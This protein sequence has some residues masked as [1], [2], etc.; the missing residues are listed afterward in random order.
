MTS[1]VSCAP[2]ACASPVAGQG[3]SVWARLHWIWWLLALVVGAL[4]FVLIRQWLYVGTYRFFVD[5]RASSAS[6]RQ[7]FDLRDGRVEPQVLV[8]EDGRLSFPLESSLPSRLHLRAVPA[9]RATLEIA[10][11]EHG[12][13]RMLYRR[14]LSEP[15]DIAQPL[16]PVRGL[17]EIATRGE[18]RLSD[19]RLVQE[20]V[21]TPWLVVLLASA[22]GAALWSARAAPVL[23]RARWAR[24]LVLGGATAAFAVGLILTASEL[25][26]RSLDE[27]LPS[28]ITLPRRELGEA[29][30]DPRWQDS[31][32]YGPRLAANV[33]TT[34]EWQHGDIV[35]LG[36]LPPG[37]ARHPVYRFPL[38]TDAEGFRNAAPEVVAPE[39]AALGDSFTDALT[40]PAELT[41][42]SLLA[43]RL[44]VGVR[45]YGTAGFGPAQELLVLKQYVLAR[46]PRLVVV[47]FFAGNDLQD[48]ERFETWQREGMTTIPGLGWKFKRVVA[49]FDQLYVMSLYQGFSSLLRA[50]SARLSRAA[51]PQAPAEYS[52]DDPAA[53]AP[54]VARFESGL[55]TLPVGGRSLAFAFLPPYLSGLQPS[56]EELLASRRFELTRAS[57]REMARLVRAQGGELV[58]MFIPSKAQ[59]YLPLLE[60]GFPAGELRQ[61][62]RFCQRAQ[63]HAPETVTLLRNRLALNQ[64]MREFCV[65]EDLA[66]LDLTADLQARLATG[67]NV[68]FPDDSHW[69]AAGHEVGA[70][71]LA[72]FIRAR[73]GPRD[74]TRHPRSTSVGSEGSGALAPRGGAV[75]EYKFGRHV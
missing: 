48:A 40:L 35:R 22:L 18:F 44:G 12:L 74:S 67:A 51:A 2:G 24:T 9:T 68:Y 28:W 23:P 71:A 7:R 6:A 49:R 17:L 8:T 32:R 10:V 25:A 55:F 30:A 60:A 72:R 62:L 52:G 19:P 73:E 38:V 26:L 41:W 53:P 33:D 64:V 14:T 3:P 54:T 21:T 47:G 20:P 70:A 27:R 69:N 42:P 61:A 65:A 66:F 58:V 11:L 37:L 1:R 13:R 39:V 29:R 43:R 16:P 63:P 34:C 5:E 45:N 31:P 50:G 56:R 36:F 57:Y 46:R 75:P 15:V 59:V 4:A